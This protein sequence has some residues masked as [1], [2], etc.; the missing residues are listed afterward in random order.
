P[1]RSHPAEFPVQFSAARRTRAGE[2]PISVR[3]G[4]TGQRLLPAV[5]WGVDFE[6]LG[7]EAAVV[8]PGASPGGRPVQNRADRYRAIAGLESGPAAELP[9]D[10]Q[11][12]SL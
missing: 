10:V 5:L 7:R 8:G 9:G 4:D 3:G 2:C 6:R 1:A 12:L 11:I